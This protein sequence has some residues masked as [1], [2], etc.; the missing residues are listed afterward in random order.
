MLRLLATPPRSRSEA[1]TVQLKSASSVDNVPNIAVGAGEGP[2]TA[3][4]SNAHARCRT[5]NVQMVVPTDRGAGGCDSGRA[6]PDGQRW[7]IIAEYDCDWTST[8]VEYGQSVWQPLHGD[9]ELL[10]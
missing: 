6:V 3:T 2:S 4:K 8:I 10:L 5:P 1:L 7:N 9:I